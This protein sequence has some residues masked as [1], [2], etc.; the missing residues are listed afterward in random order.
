VTALAAA[1]LLAGAAMAVFGLPPVDV[2]GPLHYAGVMDPLCGG[3]RSVHALMSGDPAAAWRYN[4]LSFPLVIGAVGVLLRHLAGM[5]A[6]RWVNVGIGD[7]RVFWA[8]VA[9]LAIALEIDQQRHAALLR[10]SP[11]RASLLGAVALPAIGG[12][13][14]AVIRV[15]QGHGQPAVR[16]TSHSAES[17]PEG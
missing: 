14:Y 9:V 16:R 6:G 10:T 2:H 8:I 3:T 4:P 11:D 12:A 13:V 15:V 17:R 1:G 5:A 7:R